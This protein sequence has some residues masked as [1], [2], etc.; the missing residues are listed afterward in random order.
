MSI[1][2]KMNYLAKNYR[3]ISFLSSAYLMGIFA[4]PCTL[5][6]YL[7]IQVIHMRIHVRVC[8][9][10]C[11]CVCVSVCVCVRA[12]DGHPS[13]GRVMRH[14]ITIKTTVLRILYLYL[15]QPLPL[16]SFVLV[17]LLALLCSLFLRFFLFFLYPEP[18]APADL[19]EA[20]DGW[21]PQVKVFK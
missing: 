7:R 4:L 17:F 1:R 14:H 19:M 2:P 11:V 13:G 3:Q 20:L 16:Y 15:Q 8:V 12:P 5:R 9:C 10:V 18:V 6:L 21:P